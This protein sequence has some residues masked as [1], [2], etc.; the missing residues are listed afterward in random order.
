MTLEEAQIIIEGLI[1]AST[2]PISSKEIGEIMAIEPSLVDALVQKLEVRYE[3]TAL[4]IRQV[5]GGYQIVTR[6]QLA[7]WLDKLGRP[8]IHAPLSMAAMETLA[9]IAY[10]QP[11]TKNEIEQ[12]RGVRSDSAINTL[13]ERELILEVGRKDGPGRPILYGTTDQFLIYFSLRSLQDLPPRELIEEKVN[14][15]ISNEAAVTE[16]DTAVDTMTDVDT[17]TDEAATT[18][19]E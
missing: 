4:T 8:V 15:V 19:E 9:I 6:S 1:F 14:Q 2:H 11:I 16:E 5:A 13:V 12:I 10:Q 7:P 3:H 18:K 17:V